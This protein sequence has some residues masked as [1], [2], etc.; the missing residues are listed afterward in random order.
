MRRRIGLAALV[1]CLCLT[2]LTACG[3]AGES[4]PG[5]TAAPDGTAER[6]SGVG[7]FFDTVVT[8]TLYGAPP[9]L[10]PQIWA[11]CERYE[12][13]LSKT[14]VGSDVQRINASH[15]EPVT[16]DPETWA[17]LKRAKEISALT[18]GA[19]SVTIAPLS[20][21]WD[22]TGGTNRMPTD[23]ERLAALPLVNDELLVL[24]D[25][26]T[27]TLPEGMEI[28][29]GGIAKGYIADR[30]AE[31][32]RGQVHGATLSF[33]GNVYA[34]GLKPDGTAFN[35]GIQ[36]PDAATGTPVAV[37]QATDVSLVTS[38]IYERYFM[39]GDT[40]YHHILDPETGLPA[41]SDL[42]SVSILDA[43]SM[44][45]DALATACIVLGLDGAKALLE[46]LGYDGVFILRDGSIVTTDGFADK[47]P[48]RTAESP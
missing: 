18:G 20:A 32:I 39:V 44:D 2:L 46:G 10:M 24:G 37:V 12:N 13:L 31:M 21:Q 3:G 23:E 4:L 48:F 27:V 15:G 35:L 43:S 5:A 8:L 17:I 9:E 30:V 16:V 26:Y 36:D 25:N 34:V 40:R 28:D 22:F 6:T 33:G 7:F 45:A 14:V 11:A 29:L 38:G 42:A 41:D 19:F 47:H 1:L